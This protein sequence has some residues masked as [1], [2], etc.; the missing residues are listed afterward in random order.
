[1]DA[2]FDAFLP[3]VLRDAL[4]IEASCGMLW[5]VGGA[6]SVWSGLSTRCTLGPIFRLS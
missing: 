1:M 4:G 2:R 5:I 6:L 3:G